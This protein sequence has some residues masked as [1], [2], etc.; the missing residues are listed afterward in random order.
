MA[1]R[2]KRILTGKLLKTK[3]ASLAVL[4]I[5]RTFRMGAFQ[6]HQFRLGAFRWIHT[7]ISGVKIRASYR[8]VKLIKFIRCIE[9]QGVSSDGFGSGSLPMASFVRGKTKRCH[10]EER[11]DGESLL[12]SVLTEERFLTP[13]GMKAKRRFLTAR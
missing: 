4:K 3:K 6:I 7:L 8:S 9:V 11:S 1:V 5:G 13:F 2:W 10:S 12:S